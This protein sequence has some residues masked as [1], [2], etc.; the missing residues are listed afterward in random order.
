MTSSIYPDD[1][2]LF[3]GASG[4]T[5]GDDGG[6]MESLKLKFRELTASEKKEYGALVNRFNVPGHKE[7]AD[8][9]LERAAHPK[10]IIFPLRM[11]RHLAVSLYYNTRE[12]IDLTGDLLG[13]KRLKPGNVV[14]DYSE[15][16][17]TLK[18]K[19]G[20]DAIDWDSFPNPPWT[21]DWF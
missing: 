19:Y 12:F 3:G 10:G 13:R 9:A 6:S 8:K 21:P 20:R 16:F 14:Y 18:K 5:L 11:F 17:G 15:F 4:S 1:F 7:K 2:G